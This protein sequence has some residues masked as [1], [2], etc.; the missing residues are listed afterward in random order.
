MLFLSL[1]SFFHT[2]LGT[3]AKEWQKATLNLRH[4]FP[5]THSVVCPSSQQNS[6]LRQHSRFYDSVLYLNF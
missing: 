1:I 5:A 3:F 4:N 2:Y 6:T